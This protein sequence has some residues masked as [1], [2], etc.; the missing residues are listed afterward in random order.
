MDN[1][2]KVIDGIEKNKRD[3]IDTIKS[4]VSN[5]LFY[6]IGDE[7]WNNVNALISFSNFANGIITEIYE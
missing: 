1:I 5:D 7:T 6:Y 3:M 2:F 4:N